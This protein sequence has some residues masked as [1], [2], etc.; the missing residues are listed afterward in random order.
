MESSWKVTCHWIQQH[1]ITLLLLI[2]IAWGFC[3]RVSSI[4]HQS[5]WIDEGYSINAAQAILQ[6]GYPL[7]DSG[8][9]YTN[10]PLG[11][12]T[13]AVM[14]KI[15]GLNP[16][17]PWPVRLPAVLLGTA[18]IGVTYLLAKKILR[19]NMTA[20]LV[21]GIVACSEW[22]IAWS[23]Q[24]RDYAMLQFFLLLYLYFLWLW[25]DGQKLKHLILAAA[26]LLAA[27]LAHGLSIIFVP[28]FIVIIAIRYLLRPQ[29]R[30]QSWIILSAGAVIWILASLSAT[31]F[32]LYHTHTIYIYY[33][34]YVK[35]TL[36]I[37]AT[38]GMLWAFF[39]HRRADQ[40]FFI[41]LHW[42]L[43]LAIL[44]Q[45]GEAFQIRY[46]F[47]LFPLMI[48]LT[49]YGLVRIIRL[50]RI[51]SVYNLNA[52]AL[53]VIAI[54]LFYTQLRF[55]PSAFYPLE[56]DSPQSHFKTVYQ[57]IKKQSQPTDLVLSPYAHLTKIYLGHTG[58][59]LPI[60]LTGKRSEFDKTIIDGRY[61][62]YVKAP[63]VP[64]PTDLQSLLQES[65]GFI[66]IDGM[67][68]RRLR[69]FL[70]VITGHPGMQLLYHDG[71]GLSEIWLF[72]F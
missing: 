19:N 72:K 40:L 24:A 43:P 44:I 46:L 26:M 68:R 9:I 71:K 41:V 1:K 48:L 57:L 25:L 55:L 62:Y 23:A 8:Q 52:L 15:F 39:D 38:I 20:L 3:L 42:V 58:Y 59:W 17:H 16:F 60:S 22:E 10:Q 66:V 5:L 14:I 64:K 6:H 63:I 37:G 61:D 29:Q 30:T 69:Q 27:I 4:N 31:H 35:T 2:L 51:P 33:L 11:L 49:L 53:I 54:T 65:H 34:L 7:L 45:A 21:T 70:P 18:V 47:P 12:Y 13:M 36:L 50:L 67:S 56:Y 32:K 28:I